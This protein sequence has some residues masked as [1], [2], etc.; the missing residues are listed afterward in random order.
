MNTVTKQLLFIIFS[1]SLVACGSD[2]GGSSGEG[3]VTPDIT[4]EMNAYYA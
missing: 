4:E 3:E 1:L 2:E